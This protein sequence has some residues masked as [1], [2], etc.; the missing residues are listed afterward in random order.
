MKSSPQQKAGPGVGERDELFLC[1]INRTM[2]NIAREL[3][4]K[5]KIAHEACVDLSSESREGHDCSAVASR[6]DDKSREDTSNNRSEGSSTPKK[7]QATEALSQ[8]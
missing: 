8:W 5:A 1:A 7:P 4:K 3:D 2:A 6:V